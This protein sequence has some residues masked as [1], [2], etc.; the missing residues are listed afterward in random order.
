[1]ASKSRVVV[2]NLTL[3]VSRSMLLMSCCACLPLARPA[4]CTSRQSDMA[5]PNIS[6]MCDGTL[7]VERKEMPRCIWE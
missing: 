1:M 3:G 7:V 4:A 5:L 6:T 2:R